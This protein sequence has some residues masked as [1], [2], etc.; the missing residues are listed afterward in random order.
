VMKRKL[1]LA[2]GL[3]LLICGCGGSSGGFVTTPVQ[4][5]N[6]FTLD[7][8]LDP[9]NLPS[10]VTT[11]ELI[12]LDASGQMVWEVGGAP[13][14]RL[15]FDGLPG[16]AT[17]MIVQ[18]KVKRRTVAL[19]QVELG[20]TPEI[21]GREI[22]FPEVLL[23]DE[24]VESIA[25]NNTDIEMP[26]STILLLKVRA[27]LSKGPTL[28]M[29]KDAVWIS[30]N[31]SV[32]T[33]EK[34]LVRAR[35][36][37]ETNI[38]A[39]IAGRTVQTTLT[40][41]PLPEDVPDSL[42]LGQDRQNPDVLDLENGT[43]NGSPIPG[44]DAKNQ[45]IIVK[46]IKANPGYLQCIG[47]DLVGTALESVSFVADRQE[48]N[49]AGDVY[50][51]YN[52]YTDTSFHFQ[53]EDVQASG[54]YLPT[55][56][57]T[58]PYP[59]TYSPGPDLTFI[60]TTNRLAPILNGLGTTGSNA[61][62]IHLESDSMQLAFDYPL[63]AGGKYLGGE[64]LVRAPYIAVENSLIGGFEVETGPLGS[65]TLLAENDIGIQEDADVYSFSG[66]IS[67]IARNGTV[68]CLGRLHADGVSSFSPTH[69][70]GLDAGTIRVFAPNP[71][72]ITGAYAEGGA[73]FEG[74]AGGD[75]GR[76]VVTNGGGELGVAG[77]VGSPN[78]ADGTID[79]EQDSLVVA[80]GNHTFNMSTGLFDNYG[81]PGWDA[82][83]STLTLTSLQIDD[84]ATMRITGT[85]LFSCLST[86]DVQV[87]GSLTFSGSNETSSLPAAS[88]GSMSISSDSSIALGSSGEVTSRG[89][90]GTASAG[91]GG[92]VQLIAPTVEVQGDIATTGGQGSN[93]PSGNGG[94]V[95]VSSSVSL[96]IRGLIDCSGAIGFNAAGNG[97]LI[98]LITEGNLEVVSQLLCFGGDSSAKPGNGG[99][100]NIMVTGTTTLSE[101]NCNGG[102]SGLTPGTGGTVN[103]EG[104]D[105]ITVNGPIT[106]NSGQSNT[107]KAG[108]GGS[109]G[110]NG[111]STVTID[112][113]ITANG[114]TRGQ[115]GAI[116]VHGDGGVTNNGTLTA[117]PRGTVTV[118]P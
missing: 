31:P 27:T 36:Q 33:V 3:V 102:D 7:F 69:P 24:A 100:V 39:R 79:V 63:N 30:S 60:T 38:I 9:D 82:A 86:G 53:G 13:Q 118:T 10:G 85:G 44:W 52:V 114:T 113:S 73:G 106:V 94:S 14:S 109:V 11:V 16:T 84:G 28:E 23:L 71:V 8:R 90:S 49:E 61:G 58:Y 18:Y 81:L 51:D 76:I 55:D 78:G 17:Q 40:V 29:R 21:R 22:G 92:S 2:L 50:E 12:G 46:N 35:A 4:P 43:L 5:V 111:S 48:T 57:Q 108:N 62:D 19:S 93:V 42:Q 56:Y 104:T 64:I 105:A 80:P 77:G 101:V 15:F 66:D 95:L 115:G 112:G 107:G 68:D 47:D 70:N 25:L 32:A 26:V 41:G 72:T 99:L 45:T 20:A 87:L 83:T 65:A 59:A 74:G 117:N 116:T 37:G 67:L 97:G 1:I 88:G 98:A 103:L 91:D 34:G 54:Y 96:T 89:G 75:G 6:D 110:V